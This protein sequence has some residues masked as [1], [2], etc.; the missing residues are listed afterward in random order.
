[1]IHS[2]PGL[3]LLEQLHQHHQQ[4]QLQPSWEALR[5]PPPTFGGHF[6][7]AAARGWGPRGPVPRPQARASGLYQPPPQMSEAAQSELVRSL[8]M[9]QEVPPPLP[10]PQIYPPKHTF[11]KCLGTSC[12]F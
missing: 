4:A 6:P 5:G 3:A 8:H 9:L 2:N 1:M 10:I 7:P 11:S 12:S